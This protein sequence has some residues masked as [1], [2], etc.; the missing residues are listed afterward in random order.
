MYPKKPS[1]NIWNVKNVIISLLFGL[2]NENE[3]KEGRPEMEIS[4]PNLEDFCGQSYL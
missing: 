4:K 3:H 2:F 1:F